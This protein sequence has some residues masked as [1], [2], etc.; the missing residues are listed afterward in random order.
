MPQE[1]RKEHRTKDIYYIIKSLFNLAS[2]GVAQGQD[3]NLQTG[4][5]DCVCLYT[6]AIKFYGQFVNLV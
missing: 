4:V 3:S 6:L 1:H 5:D 2:I